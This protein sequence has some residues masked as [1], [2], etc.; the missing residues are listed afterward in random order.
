M[1]MTI[2]FEKRAVAFVDVL[3]FKAL[4]DRAAS[5]NDLAPLSEL[6]NLLSSSIPSFDATVDKSVPTSLIPRHIYISDCI[7]LS[8]PISSPSRK[9]YDGLSIVVMRVIQLSHLLLRSGY[10]IRG[11]IAVGDAWHSDSNIVGPAYQE[12]LGL[13]KSG[14]EPIVVLSP[15]AAKCWEGGSRMCLQ[16]G[17]KV[18]VNSLFD[19][20]IPNRGEHG[21]ID[22][23]YQSYAA[24]AE[25][26][27]REDLSVS[28]KKKWEW[29][30]A[31]VQSEA[32]EGLKWA[33]A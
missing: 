27:V 13:E 22:S 20:Y 17:G 33:P 14:G 28:A 10:L 11:G 7:I 30:R 9:S 23:T 24:L 16:Q 12:A 29:F 3:G 8:A 15:S 6:V 31:F 2:V 19:C 21:G 18:F 1:T 26:R 32:P 25:R 4:V 5:A